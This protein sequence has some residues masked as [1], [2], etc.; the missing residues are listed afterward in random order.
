MKENVFIIIVVVVIAI[1]GYRLAENK[2]IDEIRSAIATKYSRSVSDVFIRIDKKNSNYTVGGVSFAP[3]GVAG[4]AFM[5]AKING[6]WK[7]VYDGNGS[8]DCTKIK[9]TYDFPA[10]MLIGFCD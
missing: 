3:K 1:F 2:R 8:I 4:G 6:K 5:A 7:L 9:R 10:D